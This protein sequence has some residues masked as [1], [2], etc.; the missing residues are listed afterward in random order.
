MTMASI[1]IL[2]RLGGDP[3]TKTAGSG[4]VTEFS[5]AVET[6]RG[7]E[8]STTWYSCA[9]WGK[10]GEII[11]QYAK[12]GDL[13]SV[14][15]THSAREW[16][17]KDGRTGVSQDVDVKSFAFAGGSKKEDAPSRSSSE[18]YRAPSADDD[19]AF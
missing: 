10:P 15:G 14:A 9:A 11:A 2:G 12:K 5:L 6:R 18:D 8:K 13:L 19:V 3:K 7:Q 16:T 1:T 17:G 4:T